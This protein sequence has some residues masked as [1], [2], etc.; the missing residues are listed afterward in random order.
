MIKWNSLLIETNSLR[1]PKIIKE[2]LWKEQIRDQCTAYTGTMRSVVTLPTHRSH[3]NKVFFRSYVF[4][5]TLEVN[6]A[7]FLVRL[8]FHG[9]DGP[10]KVIHQNCHEQTK[11]NEE[12][13]ENGS[14]ITHLS[15]P[16]VLNF[17]A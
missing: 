14:S 1:L 16:L 3:F 13:E 15:H 2:R 11:R 10:L 6:P 17:F 9:C 8:V 4:K 12:L 5:D 7:V